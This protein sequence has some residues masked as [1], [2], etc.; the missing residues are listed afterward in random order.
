[1]LPTVCPSVLMAL[2][3]LL[4]LLLV[5]GGAAVRGS[6]WSPGGG[7][8]LGSA[9]LEPPSGLM[10]FEPDLNKFF[11]SLIAPT[12]AL[13]PI[14]P[15]AT[16]C[17][18]KL[19]KYLGR[20]GLLSSL[21]LGGPCIFALVL[22]SFHSWGHAPQ[23][24]K[25]FSNRY[26]PGVGALDGEESERGN[27]RVGILSH[28]LR[29][30]GAPRRSAAFALDT[31]EY[32]ADRVLGHA[33]FLQNMCVNAWRRF[34]WADKTYTDTLATASAGT[35]LSSAF[36]HANAPKYMA[37]LLKRARDTENASAGV[38]PTLLTPKEKLQEKLGTALVQMFSLEGNLDALGRRTKLF[39]PTPV[40]LAALA[41][42][43]ST[44]APALRGGLVAMQA[45]LSTL[46][47]EVRRCKGAL[48]RLGAATQPEVAA[49]AYVTARYESSLVSTMDLLQRLVDGHYRL[50][51]RQPFKTEK[52]KVEEG[53]TKTLRLLKDTYARARTLQ[54]FANG[55]SSRRPLPIIDF[56]PPAQPAAIASRLDSYLRGEHLDAIANVSA[57]N[58]V[59]YACATV[60]RAAEEVQSAPADLLIALQAVVR[61]E[62]GLQARE[63]STR[64]VS[65]DAV[66][67]PDGDMAS[68]C[69]TTVHANPHALLGVRVMIF[70]GLARTRVLLASLKEA[71]DFVFSAKFRAQATGSLRGNRRTRDD[72]AGMGGAVPRTDR[73]AW[74]KRNREAVGAAA[75]AAAAGVPPPA[76]AAPARPTR[77]AAVAAAAVI[78]MAAPQGGT[79]V[80]VARAA[81]RGDDYVPGSSDDEV[82]DD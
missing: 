55:A 3:L 57:Y 50:S 2:L 79:T 35:K 62:Q 9:E 45:R 27:A 54:P 7:L 48:S 28:V 77:A 5:Q 26:A 32:G 40:L 64:E 4:L 8:F 25:L 30:M 21:L 67:V 69:A 19:G 24:S 78:T 17:S 34:Y 41:D 66:T 53:N 71:C 82:S 29:A 20:M 76:V 52:R 43:D 65:S 31:L 60:L 13:L 70:E 22:N 37:D 68:Y 74:G 36:L 56:D 47:A 1:M 81:P 63:L 10:P 42:Y 80:A 33:K 72:W 59:A 16:D 39:T 11:A 38:T 44:H 14:V 15:F 49:V 23:C 58:A 73:A 12:T 51:D 61:Q 18:C 75:V 46:R 6:Q